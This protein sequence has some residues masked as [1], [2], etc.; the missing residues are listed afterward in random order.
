MAINEEIKLKKPN[1]ELRGYQFK[2]LCCINGM[3]QRTFLQLIISTLCKIQELPRVERG[4]DEASRPGRRV[5]RLAGDR[6]HATGTERRDV[7]VRS[8]LRGG[9]QKGRGA[10]IF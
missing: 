2:N 9:G 1:Y 5:Q 3:V 6:R 10:Q 4:V 8:R 7:Q